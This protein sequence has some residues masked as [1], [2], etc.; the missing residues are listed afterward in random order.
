MT[1]KIEISYKTIVFT[2]VFIISLLFLYTIRDTI[3]FLFVVIIVAAALSPLVNRLEGFKIPR[4]LAIF[5]IYLLLIGGFVVSVASAIPALVSETSALLEGLPEFLNKIG[6]FK[7]NLKPGDYSDQLAKIPANFFKIAA[8]AFS[9]LIRLF[10]F[11]VIDFYLL[12]ERKNLKHHLH[13]LFSG[14]GEKKVEGII[15]NLESKLGGWVRGE[16]FLMFIVGFMSY[17]GL[18]LLDLDF[19]L[20]LALMAGFLELIPNIGPTFAMIPAMI[21]GFGSSPL[22]GLAVVALYILIQQ[23]ENNFI[24]PKV[25]QKAVGLHPLVTLIALMLGFRLGGIGGTLLAVPTLLF[26]R[27]LIENLYLPSREGKEKYSNKIPKA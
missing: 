24:V 10:T 15:L 21:V 2:V 3:L 22:I 27:V 17:A 4:P 12:M 25:M 7:L 5:L 8:S 1:E 23:L 20:P 26:I 11:F 18:K 19:V 14:D 6:F 9:N 13:F 16:L